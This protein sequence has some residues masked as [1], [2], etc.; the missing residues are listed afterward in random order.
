MVSFVRIFALTGVITCLTVATASAGH[1]QE[2]KGFWIALG[3]GYGWA[4]ASCEICG[5][6]EGGGASTGLVRLG[7]AL[8]QK[9]LL[10]GEFN[11]WWN[12]RF[13]DTLVLY[14]AVAT[15]SFYP[16][17]ASGFFVRGG[18]GGSF[19]D[20][21]TRIGNTTVTTELGSGLGLLAGAG[22]DI[23]VG[24]QISITPALTYWTGRSMDLRF[25]N[26]TQTE[27]WHHNVVDITVAVTFH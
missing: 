7:W 9:V 26:S 1:P 13:D 16:S 18:I 20:T 21:S 3:F 22:Y 8:N 10:G 5:D 12:E 27:E 25:E 23:R 15:A 11:F 4:D 19:A 2:R 17:E 24:R 14:D 6:E